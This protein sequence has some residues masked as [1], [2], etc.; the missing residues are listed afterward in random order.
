MTQLERAISDADLVAFAD[1]RLDPSRYAEVEAWISEHPDDRRTVEKW[2]KQTTLLKAALDPIA[3]EPLPAVLTDVLKPRGQRRSAW[4]GLAVAA[5]IA[6]TVGLGGGWYLGQSGFL[7]PSLDKD[8]GEVIAL[9]GFK[10]HRLYTRE[11]RH[12]VEV[13]ADDETHL[14]SWLSKRL[15]T[16]LKAPDLTGE[17]LRLLGGRLIPIDGNPAAQLMYESANGDR[18]TLFASRA[19]GAKP[20]ALHFED[21]DSIGCFYW[22]DGDVGYALNGPNDRERLMEIATKV[23][24]QLS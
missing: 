16:T 20:T 10:A 19:G 13:G 5:S 24:E 18:Y 21:W 8:T 4:I 2:R 3:A 7:S 9:A 1:E 11:V 22:I 14:V 6:L 17:G 12:P 23:Y 15:D